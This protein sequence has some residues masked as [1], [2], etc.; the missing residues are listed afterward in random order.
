MSVRVRETTHHGNYYNVREVELPNG[1]SWVDVQKMMAECPYVYNVGA[2]V[3]L[4][5]AHALHGNGKMQHGWTDWDVIDPGDGTV[6]LDCGHTFDE[7]DPRLE[8]D[9]CP[10]CF[11]QYH[12][13]ADSVG[14][15][16]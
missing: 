6:T 16:K 7:D 2:D 10:T 13:W 4:D 15:N 14:R 12:A 3:A 9:D 5:K 1:Y 11:R 8:S